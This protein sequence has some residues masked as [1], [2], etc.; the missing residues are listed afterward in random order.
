MNTD[1]FL[2][3]VF[4]WR[5]A[6]L[7][8]GGYLLLS[9]FAFPQGSL[10]PPGAPAPTFKT[11]TQVEPRTIVNATNTPGDAANTFIISQSGSYYLTGNITGASGKHGISIQANDV[12]LDLNGF[13]LISGGGGAFRGVNVPAA[14]NNLC[15]RNGTVRGWTDGGV[16]TDLT[17]STFAEKLR[18]SDNVGATGL[19]L[20]NGSAKDCVA[21]GNATGFIVGNGAQI[22]GSAASANTT[23]FVAGDRAQVSNCIATIN[24]DVGFRCTDIVTLIDCTAS[25]NLGAA[26]IVVQGRCTVIRCNASRNIPSANGITA[27]AGCTIADCTAGSNGLVGISVDT[28]STVRNCTVQSNG[29]DG[30]LATSRCNLTGNTCDLNTNGGIEVISSSGAQKTRVDGNSCTANSVGIIINGS[31]I[32]VIRNSA[33]GNSSANFN[34]ASSSNPAGPIV[35]MTGGGTIT[36][37]SPWANFIY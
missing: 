12:T 30:I 5:A 9:T 17:T 31:N 14:Q 8:V 24:T 15:V 18:L 7:C 25:R 1:R 21:T 10:T 4:R 32:L 13:A 28:G 27:G 35:D 29:S 22:T 16:R 19:A 6:A 3:R 37:P 11:L 23:G 2:L 36:S 34:I 26:G 20:G 33:S